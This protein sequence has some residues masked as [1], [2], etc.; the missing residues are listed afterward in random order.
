MTLYMPLFKSCSTLRTL[1]QL[2]AHLLVTGLHRDVLA[3]TKL[4][5]SYAKM[6]TLESATTVFE[7]FPRPD[8]FIWGVLIRCCVRNGSFEQAISL[9][10][11][12]LHRQTQ[13]SSFVFSSILRA[14]S[15]FGDLGIGGDVHGRIIKCGVDTDAIVGTSL[16]RMYG[17]NDCLDDARKIFDQMLIR[18][19]VSWCSIIASYVQNGRASEGLEMFH[20]MVSERI[21]PDSVI[22]LSVIEACAELGL[23]RLARSVH[24]YIIR[25]DLERH[26]S[27][28]NSLIVMYSKFGDLHGAECLFESRTVWSTPSWTSMIFCYN[29][30]GCFREA[31]NILVEMQESK[32]EPNSV[33]MMGILYSCARLGRLKEGKS[34]HCFVIRKA[35]DPD[36]QFL[37]PALIDFYAVC[38]K[39]EYSQKAFDSVSDRNIVL[40]NVLISVYARKRL[41]NEALAFFAQMHEQGFMPDSF[42]IASSL[43]ACGDVHFSQLGSQIHGHIVKTGFFNEFVQNSLIDMYSKC[44]FVDLASMIFGEIPNKS[45][46]TWNSMICGF[47]QNGN[48]VEAIS[49]FDQMYFNCVEMDN[50]TFLSAIQACSHL[51]YL[52]KGKWVH[53]KLITFGIRKDSHTETALC[54]MYAKCGDL[55]MAQR[56]FDSTLERNVVS[57]SAMIAG[58]GMHGQTNAAI[59]LFTQMLESGIKPNNVTFLNIL[60]A[61]SHTGLVKE[62]KLYF[63]LMGDF[64]IEPKSE[65]FAC[66]VDLLSRAGDINGAYAIISSMPFPANASIWGALLN[67]CRIHRRMDMITIIQRKLLDT[68]TDDAGHYT[69]LS[70]IYVEGGNLHDFGKVRSMMRSIGL[71]KVP[72]HS[73]VQIDTKF[74]RFEAGDTSH[75]QTK[76]IYRFLENFLSFAQELGYNAEGY[77][78]TIDTCEFFPKRNDV[79]NHSEKL[80]I[81][82]GIINTS[83]RTT[84]HISKNLRICSDCHS[85]TKIVSRITG[86]QIIMRDLNRFHHFIDGSCSCRDYW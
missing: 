66:M 21:K 9:Y 69:L 30:S 49:L 6:G 16:V 40:W 48:S 29:Q 65:H 59:S 83:P 76:E 37:G 5:D 3:S 72:G 31:L 14:C 73:T 42:T 33:T 54:D 81:A 38:G 32:V 24:G 71:Q 52:E 77:S 85:F 45:T 84:L 67:G 17:E 26:G 61:C 44:G 75:N 4:I 80:A 25:H 2:H 62:G 55:H 70:N 58:Y 43:S 23:F 82:F 36:F 20:Q 63:N 86:R 64:G 28:D 56:V 13:I 57:W 47:S 19:V 74:Y 78:C 79:M 7:N 39:P 50:V 41:S 60:S 10:H 8:S 53:H 51:C 12:M 27:L 46:I 11:E 1:S 68:N 22:M 35:Q 18:D 15:G 34:V